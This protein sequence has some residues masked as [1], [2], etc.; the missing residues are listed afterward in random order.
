MGLFSWLG[1]L[2]KRKHSSTERYGF[3]ELEPGSPEA[4]QALLRRVGEATTWAERFRQSTT[5]DAV[6]GRLQGLLTSLSTI[7]GRLETMPA[8]H[9]A[10]LATL[11]EF[12]TF[13]E[14]V[15]AAG[16]ADSDQAREKHI[17]A[18]CDALTRITAQF[19]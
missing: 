2:F 1:S 6:R 3:S 8:A 5:T 19:A 13:D 18:A 4:R 16:S 7:R 15:R 11:Q 14:A 17:S 10:R 9:L 12:D